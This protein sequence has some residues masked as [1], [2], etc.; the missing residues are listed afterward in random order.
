MT[1]NNVYIHSQNNLKKIVFQYILCIIPLVFYGIYKN[2]FLLWNR[3]LMTFL[4][5]F[6]LIYLLLISIGIYFLIY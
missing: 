4:A 2:G 3:D 6:K 1:E 5:I